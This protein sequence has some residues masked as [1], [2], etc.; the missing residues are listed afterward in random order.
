MVTPPSRLDLV[1]TQVRG[2]LERSSA[3]QALQPDQRTAFA[4]DLVRV[5]DY[6]ADPEWIAQR[7]PAR[8]RALAGSDAVGELKNRLAQAPGQVGQEFEAGAVNAGVDAFRRMVQTVDFPAFVSGLIQ[9]VFRAIVDAS[10]EQMKAYGE[11]LAAVSKSVD[12]FADETVS[13]GQAR[14]FL[15]SR[16]PSAVEVDTSGETSRL[17]LRPEAEDAAQLGQDFGLANV[18]LDDEAS[19]LQLVN[20]AKLEMARSRQQLMATMVLLG[21]NRIIVTNGRINAKVVFDMRASDEASRSAK[22]AMHDSESTQVAAAAATWP[23]WGAAA[24]GFSHNHVATVSSAVDDDSES[25]ASVKAQLT[26]EVRVSFRSETFP[27]E[28]LADN[29]TLNVLTAKAQPGTAPSGAA[30]AGA[31]SS[32]GGQ[33]P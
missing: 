16:Y 4:K 14:D 19:E 10:M 6:L 24:A 8:A 27:L 29:Q 12:Q 23:P 25:K 9:G 28:R 18:D 7:T 11:L 21:I 20:A 32:A 31:A 26:G 1:R 15:A 17:K 5:G 22:A 30:P 13:E 33:N 2:L 3:F